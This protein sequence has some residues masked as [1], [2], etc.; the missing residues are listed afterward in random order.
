MAKKYKKKKKRYKNIIEIKTNR[1]GWRPVELLK[2]TNSNRLVVK[3]IS[4]QIIVGK[5]R[6]VHF[7]RTRKISKG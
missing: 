5:F 6:G 2:I 7:T 1:H 3:T 4:G